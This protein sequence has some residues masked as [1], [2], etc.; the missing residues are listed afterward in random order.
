MREPLYSQREAVTEWG[1]ASG[2]KDAK[3]A[4]QM[5]ILKHCS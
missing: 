2:K 3:R 4:S 1:K 5:A